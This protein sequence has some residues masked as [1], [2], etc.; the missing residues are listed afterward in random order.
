[1]LKKTK[2]V[3]LYT[4]KY[5]DSSVIV[6]SFTETDGRMSFWLRIPKTNKA[7]VKNV[8]FQPLS[9]LELDIDVNSKGGLSHIREA[10][11]AT[12]LQSI[13]FNPLKMSL[14]LF[15]AEY[16]G[17]VL[18]EEAKNEVLYAYLEH[19]ILWLDSCT[20]VPSNFH[21]VFLMRFSRFLG[22]F[23]NLEDYH[24]GDYFDLENGCFVSTQPFH[25]NFVKGVQAKHIMT[26]MRM[27]YD[28]MHIFQMNRGERNEILNLILRYYEIHIPTCTGLKS[29]PVLQELFD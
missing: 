15:I 2:A 29:L 9:I 20:G 22:L 13:P 4:L 12:P 28:T 25:G 6:H 1:M 14:A 8:L 18:R 24:E 23:P 10:R 27:N 16:L 7:K 21:L 3:I 19:S 5:G 11:A 26:L 17:K